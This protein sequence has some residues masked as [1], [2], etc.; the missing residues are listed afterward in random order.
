ML[1][2]MILMPTLAAA[3]LLLVPGDDAARARV[4][5]VGALAVTLVLLGMGIALLPRTRRYSRLTSAGRS[6]STASA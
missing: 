5:R 3:A 2:F 1:S 6:V 4:A